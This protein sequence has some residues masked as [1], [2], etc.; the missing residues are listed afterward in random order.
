[1]RLA[2]L[3]GLML[4][5]PLPVDAQ[6]A[7]PHAGLAE[8]SRL[9]LEPHTIDFS[10]KPEEAERLGFVTSPNRYRFSD[11]QIAR[12][13]LK[14]DDEYGSSIPPIVLHGAAPDPEAYSIWSAP[15]K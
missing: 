2:A 12:L 4:L 6:R 14:G 10:M 9:C 5:A 11:E 1:M 8:F 13:N 7:G 3:L 15:E